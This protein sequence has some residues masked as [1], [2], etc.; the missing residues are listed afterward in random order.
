MCKVLIIDDDQAIRTVLSTILNGTHSIT[1]AKSAEEAEMLIGL[2]EP[3][4]IVLDYRL[5]S[6]VSGLEFL[7]RLPKN[8]PEVIVVT[9]SG[10]DSELRSSLL[11][12]GALYVVSKPYDLEELR[13]MIEKAS[14][15]H[16]A[17]S[18]LNGVEE[19]QSGALLDNLRR[20]VRELELSRGIANGNR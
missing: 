7:R 13:V 6:G 3:D 10:A 14:R 5:P 17:C 12:A 1:T 9:G 20:S 2:F 19:L 15:Y 11:R 8:R 4:V 16:R 18:M